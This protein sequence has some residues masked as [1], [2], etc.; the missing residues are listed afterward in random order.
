M[1]RSCDRMTNGAGTYGDHGCALERDT[2]E[3][4]REKK[5]KRGRWKDG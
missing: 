2:V 3:E 5:R 1:G 4:K